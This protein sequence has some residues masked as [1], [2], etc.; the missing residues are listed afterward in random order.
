MRKTRE[1]DSAINSDNTN[2]T[3]NI[4]NF[5][6]NNGW[7]RAMVSGFF[8]TAVIVLL[9]LASTGGEVQFIYSRF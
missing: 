9:V 5:T 8:W 7:I 3:G 4:T 6:N 2:N 1:T